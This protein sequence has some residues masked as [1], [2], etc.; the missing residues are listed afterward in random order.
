MEKTGEKRGHGQAAPLLVDHSLAKANGAR[1]EEYQE[2]AGEWLH[3]HS[4]QSPE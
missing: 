4:P 2:W 3:T 1:P